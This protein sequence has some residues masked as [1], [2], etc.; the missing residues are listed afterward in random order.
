[1]KTVKVQLADGSVVDATLVPT[2]KVVP[3][4]NRTYK[5]TSTCPSSFKG[6]QR[7]IVRDVIATDKEKYWTIQEVSDLARSKGLSAV[8]GV[9]ESVRYHLHNLKLSQHVEERVN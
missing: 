5:I 6:K 7:Q 8:G 3:V 9:L 2:S 4:L 1:M